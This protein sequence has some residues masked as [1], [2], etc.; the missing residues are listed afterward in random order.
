MTQLITGNWK[1]NKTIEEATNFIQELKKHLRKDAPRVFLAVPFTAINACQREADGSPLVIGAQNMNDATEGA[2]TGEIAAKM[3]I[4]A[5]AK[6]VLL[7]H[8]ERRH[9]FGETNSFINKKVLRALKEGIQPVLCIGET[10]EERKGG[11]EHEVLRTQL[12][13]GLA[14]VEKE[15]MRG[16]I[17]AYEPV[18][19]VGTDETATP[20]LV[21]EALHFVREVLVELFGEEISSSVILQY[22]GSVRPDNAERLLKEEEVGGLLIGGASLV[23]DFFIQ[24]I[25]NAYSK[26]LTEGES[27]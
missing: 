24:I 7:G 15:Q 9:I 3:L 17:I 6:F 11:R 18:W 1:M 5:G 16:A 23:L 12:N 4:D 21:H 25:D 10:L 27:K 13:E 2:F 20:E 19:A 26:P 14:G 8:S 22:G